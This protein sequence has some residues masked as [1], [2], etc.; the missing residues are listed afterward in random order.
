MTEILGFL[1]AVLCQTKLEHKHNM[2]LNDVTLTQKR[3]QDEVTCRKVL[4]IYCW[5]YKTTLKTE[6]FNSLRR[7]ANEQLNINP[8][9]MRSFILFTV[10]S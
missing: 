4:L 2:A 8:N 5:R 9:M 1:C 3:P 10:F 7:F 6:Q